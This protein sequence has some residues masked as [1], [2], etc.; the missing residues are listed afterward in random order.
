[1]ANHKSAEK[2]NRQ[3]EVTTTRSRGVRSYVRTVLAQARIA[4]AD[5]TDDAAKL[6]SRACSLLDRAGSRNAFPRK[7]V[8]RLKSRLAASLHRAQKS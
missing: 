5:G 3:R 7:R 2:R 1:M 4:V 8:A 6:V